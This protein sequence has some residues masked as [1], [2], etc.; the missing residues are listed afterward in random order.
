MFPQH[1]SQQAFQTLSHHTHTHMYTVTIYNHLEAH[2]AHA[3]HSTHSTHAA[4]WWGS[5]LLWQFGHDSLRGDEEGGDTSGINK[6]SADHLSGVNNA[7]LNHVGVFTNG[8]VETV[9]DIGFA[10]D[11]LDN[12]STLVAC[13]VSNLLGGGHECPAHNVDAHLLVEVARLD[14]V[15]L[16]NAAQQCTPTAGHNA[17]LH[18]STGGVECVRHTVLLLTNLDLAGTTNLDDG[19]TTGKTGK[20]L[21]ELLLLVLRG[22]G[23][24]C[25]PDLVAALINA[26]LLA[27][28][29]HEQGVV[30]GH[31]HL[32]DLAK[33]V[34]GHVLEL[35]VKC[36]VTQHN[37]ASHDGHIV[38]SVLAIVA[39][40]WGLD[41][42]NLQ[43]ATELVHNKRAEGLAI[44][45][46][47]HNDEGLSH[48]DADLKGLDNLVHAADLLLRQKHQGVLEL[49]LLVLGAVDEEGGDVAAVK[50]HAL[51]NL[52]LIV[53]CL[54][55]LD[56][57][58]TLLADGLHSLSNELANLDVPI[59]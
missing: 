39:K 43:L 35:E 32:V 8:G 36:V 17:L 38:Q 58:H 51:G 14:L 53:E 28:T 16:G 10:E 46:L 9:V 59:G 47:G 29:T 13:V 37:T 44:D 24:G 25:L 34:R 11:I 45:V 7:G 30:L 12:D 31:A 21:L 33:L 52:Q 48:L 15:Q 6:S 23:I 26:V 1:A 49:N 22:G 2:A 57:D 54:A 56:S 55:V 3:A 4:H 42:G 19:N 50:L 40:A 27:S 41:C 20:A 18:G 5:V